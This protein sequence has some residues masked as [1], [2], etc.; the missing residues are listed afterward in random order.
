MSALD[1]T[2]GN[3]DVASV[4]DDVVISRAAHVTP[5]HSAS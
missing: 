3:R 1:L 5:T 4:A 2:R